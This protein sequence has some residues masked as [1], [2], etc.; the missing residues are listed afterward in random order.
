MGNTLQS[1]KK[2]KRIDSLTGLKAIAML[3]LFWWH[4]P[5]PNPPADLGAR[6]CEILFVASGFLVGYNYFYKGMPC[7]L[8]RRVSASGMEFRSGCVL[9]LQRDRVVF[10]GSDILLFYVAATSEIRQKSQTVGGNV[11]YCRF[12]QGLI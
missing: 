11:Y 7:S 1:S 2:P 12:H 8:C 3:S 10:V 4:S 9:F 5:I 6:A